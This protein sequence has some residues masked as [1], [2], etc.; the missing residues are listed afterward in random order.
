MP[1]SKI[2]LP[3]DKEGYSVQYGSNVLRTELEGGA[4][5]YRLDKIGATHLVNVQF[6][7]DRAGYDYFKAFYRTTINYGADPFII[8]LVIDTDEVDEYTARI[9][10]GSLSLKEQ[11]GLS[12]VVVAQLEVDAI[13]PD[14]EDD[15]DIVEEYLNE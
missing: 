12:Y 2:K 5:R 7:T 3:I 11:S 10:P 9:V 4:G 15:A 14:A 1:L 6:R 8:D 13:V